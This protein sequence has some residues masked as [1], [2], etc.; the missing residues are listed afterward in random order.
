MCIA[1]CL[2]ACVCLK[3]SHFLNSFNVVTNKVISTYSYRNFYVKM[4]RPT[5]KYYCSTVVFLD[6]ESTTQL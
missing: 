5:P 4:T 1:G 6:T 3:K 2:Y